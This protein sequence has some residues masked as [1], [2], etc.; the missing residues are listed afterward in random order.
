MDE[1]VEAIIYNPRKGILLQKKTLDYE[2]VPGG[3]WTFFGGWRKKHESKEKALI[4][5]IKEETGRE[6]TNFKL[7]DERE[8]IIPSTNLPFKRNVYE[9]VVNW[10]VSDISLNEGGGFCLF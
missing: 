6:I 8:D 3:M 2:P 1:T 5:E 7:F 9:I 4:R 10:N